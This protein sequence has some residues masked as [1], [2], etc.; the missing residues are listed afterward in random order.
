MASIPL[1]YL[2]ANRLTKLFRVLSQHPSIARK[3]HATQAFYVRNHGNDNEGAK[4]HTFVARGME[5]GQ[6]LFGAIK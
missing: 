4:G 1:Q 3:A 5:G 6:K 2:N